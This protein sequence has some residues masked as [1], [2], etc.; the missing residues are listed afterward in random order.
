MC[1]KNIFLCLKISSIPEGSVWVCLSR[2]TKTSQDLYPETNLN[3]GFVFTQTE[4]TEFYPIVVSHAITFF[5][6]VIGNTVVIFTWTGKGRLRSPT[7]SFLVS[8]AVADLLLILVHAPL[9]IFRYFFLNMDKEGQLCKVASYIEMLS[10][11][12]SYTYYV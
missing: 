3:L 11:M 12:V 6:G 9:E 7:A 8:L 4:H 5:I 1:T 2:P 10:G